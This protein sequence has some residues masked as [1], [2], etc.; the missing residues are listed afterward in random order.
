VFEL[1]KP[2]QAIQIGDHVKHT[3]EIWNPVG[4]LKVI[5]VS[6]HA[7]CAVDQTGKKFT[8]TYT[9]FIKEQDV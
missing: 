1:R 3:V 2:K 6:E 4:R 9:C 8:G 5:K 7:V